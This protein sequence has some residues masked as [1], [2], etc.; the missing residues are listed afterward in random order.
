MVKENNLCYGLFYFLVWFY[1]DDLSIPD[2]E[3]HI[4]VG[5]NLLPSD[6]NSEEER[7]YFQEPE[8]FLKNG[9][10]LDVKNLS[11]NDILRADQETLEMIY[12]LEG[13][14]ILLSDTK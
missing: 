4:F 10:F 1:D 3:T 2:I 11:E 7:W 5:K 12:D 6:K 8:S 13:L 14:I 9:L